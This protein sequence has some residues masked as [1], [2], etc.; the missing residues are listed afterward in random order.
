MRLAPLTPFK[1][2][3]RWRTLLGLL[4]AVLLV[5]G[6]VLTGQL[7]NLLP[8]ASS[9]RAMSTR[10]VEAPAPT[11]EP[12]PAAAPP[13]P[14]PVL[15]APVAPK[16]LP[17]ATKKAP[18]KPDVQVFT[19][20]IATDTVA[21]TT[22]TDQPEIAA[23]PPLETPLSTEQDANAITP[24][25]TVAESIPDPQ[26]TTP[27]ITVTESSPD[28]QTTATQLPRE[29]VAQKPAPDFV[30]P[31]SGS[32][33]FN[34]VQARGAQ[35]QSA[36]GTLDWASDGRTYQLQ[37]EGKAA[38]ISMFRRTSVGRL[39]PTG[40][41]PERFSEKRFNRSEQATH[42]RKDK[43]TIS[44]ANNKPDAPLLSGAQDQLSMM[45]QLAGIV[46]GNAT[47]KQVQRSVQL[48]VAGT[49]EAD[50]WVFSVE[51]METIM[52]PAGTTTALH[53]LRAPRK[54]FD[55]RVELWLAP[56]LGYMPVRF[57]QTEQNGDTFD[58]LLRSPDVRMP[59]AVSNCDATKTC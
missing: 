11:L 42:F 38:F 44:F 45:L 50:T 6:T 9:G 52:L 18:N 33:S 43:G 7:S 10:M 12:A 39:G 48:Q 3:M 58:L 49:D 22:A 14:A 31:A 47:K 4:V 13:A 37:L 28:P 54:E 20:Q 30:F 32:L 35:T 2:P 57:K 29:S 16:I 23:T 46:G 17:R 21:T 56:T 59:E 34:A 36:S 1:P 55:R 25:T 5:H 15:K 8:A 19:A 40:L 53:L 24:T 41:Q 51:G 26:T 27:S